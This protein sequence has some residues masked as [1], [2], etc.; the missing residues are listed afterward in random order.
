MQIWVQ[1]DPQ[2]T[3]KFWGAYGYVSCFLI[4]DHTPWSRKSGT[5][6]KITPLENNGPGFGAFQVGARYSYADFNDKDILGGKGSSVTLGAHWWMNPNSRIQ[7]NYIHGKITNR[8]TGS[9]IVSGSYDIVG[10]R[11]MVF[12]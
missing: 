3:T 6:G 1:R 9:G 8:L 4:G 12:F 7:F 10:T 2:K 11:F 5:L